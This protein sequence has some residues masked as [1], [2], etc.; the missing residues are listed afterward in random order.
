ML[1]V[2]LAPSLHPPRHGCFNHP[3]PANLYFQVFVLRGITCSLVLQS[4]FLLWGEALFVL[5]LGVY[6]FY[7]LKNNLSIWSYMQGRGGSPQLS[8]LVKGS[9][10]LERTMPILKGA[11]SQDRLNVLTL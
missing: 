6:W 1:G 10:R 7:F 4:S 8:P 11:S 5:L 3:T 9:R 2:L